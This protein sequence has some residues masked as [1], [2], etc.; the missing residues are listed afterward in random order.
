MGLV[1]RLIGEIGAIGILGI[2]VANQIDS[3]DLSYAGLTVLG[4][5]TTGLFYKLGENILYKN[6]HI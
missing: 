5:A 6:S 3:T 2:E 4:I 1:E